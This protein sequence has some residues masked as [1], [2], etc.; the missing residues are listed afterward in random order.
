MEDLPSPAANVGLQMMAQKDS[1]SWLLLSLLDVADFKTR[2]SAD[3][4]G[5]AKYHTAS[6]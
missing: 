4:A 5:S 3:P 2:A 6:Q 1:S